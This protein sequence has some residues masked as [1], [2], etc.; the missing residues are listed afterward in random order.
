MLLAD[1]PDDGGEPH[2]RAAR[3][4]ALPHQVG[5]ALETLKYQNYL[6]LVIQL[7]YLLW[8]GSHSY[9]ATSCQKICN[10][11]DNVQAQQDLLN[12]FLEISKLVVNKYLKICYVTKTL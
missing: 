6:F 11:V 4:G 7:V 2:R 8:F 9:F 10:F 3:P 5:A 1:Q 12:V